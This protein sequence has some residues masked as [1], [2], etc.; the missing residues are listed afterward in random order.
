MLQ[1]A[2]KKARVLTEALPYI[3]DFK[4]RFIVVKLGGS[5]QDDPATLKGIF[6]DCQ[7]LLAVGMRPVVVYGGGKR[8]SAAMRRTGRSAR[9][10]H[11]QR[12]TDADT[13]AIA[14]RVLADEVGGDLLALLREAGGDGFLLNGR[15]H[16]FLRAVKKTLPDRPGDDLGF[17]GEPVAIDSTPVHRAFEG[18]LWPDGKERLPLIA[19][20]ACGCGR[21]S[22]L[23]YNVNGDAAAAL[24]ARDLHAEKLVFISDIPGIHRDPGVSGDIFSHLDPGEIGSL[25]EKGIIAGGMIPKTEACL[26]A[27]EGGVKKVHIVAGTLPHALLLEIFTRSGVGTEIVPEKRKADF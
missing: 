19:P 12:V 17:V 6:V 15:D 11:G 22:R 14:A 9:F 20:V 5:A 10:I 3:R 16:A 26:F 18:S 8:I 27:L 25:R 24:V 13:M 21:E 2:L 4:N 1:E 23:L 7:I